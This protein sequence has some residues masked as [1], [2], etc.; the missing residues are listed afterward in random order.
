MTFDLIITIIIALA[1]SAVSGSLVGFF[2][3]HIVVDYK[4]RSSDWQPLFPSDEV[5]HKVLSN[6]SETGLGSWILGIVKQLEKN[7]EKYKDY[8]R[9]IQ[10]SNST[11]V[12]LIYGLFILAF[13]LWLES[14]LMAAIFAV[15][16]VLGYCYAK[17]SRRVQ[18]FEE[19]PFPSI[20][21]APTEYRDAEH[22]YKYWKYYLDRTDDIV[23]GRAAQFDY[24][25][26]ES[27]NTASFM[28]LIAVALIITEII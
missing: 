15:F 6:S 8:K 18:I 2:S 21:P 14:I 28:L 27:K 4:L 7:H 25:Q 3:A 9:I 22:F 1:I 23:S 17:K 20:Q 5:V 16:I 12:F 19:L 26:K 13:Y 10:R 24:M 11:I